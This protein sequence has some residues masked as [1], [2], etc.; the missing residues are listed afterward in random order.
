MTDAIDLEEEVPPLTN[1]I[2]EYIENYYGP[3]GDEDRLFG[4][5][6][7]RFNVL[8]CFDVSIS[9]RLGQDL[10]CIFNALMRWRIGSQPT[11]IRIEGDK[12]QMIAS[13]I[14][15]LKMIE[16]D[17]LLDTKDNYFAYLCEPLVVLHLS[18]T[19]AQRRET[20]NLSWL[21]DATFTAR[22]NSSLGFVFEEAVLMIILKCLEASL[23]PCL[24][25]STPTSPGARER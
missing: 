23:V 5:L 17:R 4:K 3:G 11:A 16:L 10:C 7:S 24:M 9:N 12:H 21:S 13:G 1:S 15:H 19:F 14:G 2:L 25:L 8:L 22:K 20:T 18:S 6:N